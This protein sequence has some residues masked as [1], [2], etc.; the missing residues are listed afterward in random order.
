MF[1][2]ATLCVQNKRDERYTDNGFLRHMKMDKTKFITLK[3]NEGN[4]TFGDIGSSKIIW[5][6]ILN[7]DNGRPKT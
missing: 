7:I 1:I 5:E 4:V 6:G 3:K 2:Q